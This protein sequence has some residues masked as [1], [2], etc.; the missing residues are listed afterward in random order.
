MQP[1]IHTFLVSTFAS[2]DHDRLDKWSADFVLFREEDCSQISS[3]RAGVA[4]A[5]P[6]GDESGGFLPISM[7]LRIDCDYV[8]GASTTTY[9]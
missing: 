6:V 7:I 9:P 1:E 8:V 2:L 3:R 4:T 5:P